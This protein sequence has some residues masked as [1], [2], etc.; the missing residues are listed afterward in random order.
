MSRSRH[1]R[2]SLILESATKANG[3]L[4]NAIKTDIR[5]VFQWFREVMRISE[6]QEGRRSAVVFADVHG[7]KRTLHGQAEQTLRVCGREIVVFKYE[8]LVVR[9]SFALPFFK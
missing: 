2:R 1:A 7:V 3:L 8:R 6:Q 9:M 4:P 5:P